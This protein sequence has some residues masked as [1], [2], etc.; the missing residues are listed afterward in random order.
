MLETHIVPINLNRLSLSEFSQLMTT[1]LRALEQKGVKLE[2]FPHIEGAIKRLEA[3]LPKLDVG[4][5]QEKPVTGTD[6]RQA[7]RVRAQDL[8]HIF[9]MVSIALASRKAEKREAAQELDKLLQHYRQVSRDNYEKESKHI[10]QLLN[11][12]ASQSY[13]EKISQVGI[14]EQ[15]NNLKAS[16]E[17][18]YQ[19]YLTHTHYRGQ[20]IGRRVQYDRKDI[21]NQYKILYQY[22]LCHIYWDE[23]SPLK[24]ILMS[25]ND[26]RINYNQLI[27]RREKRNKIPDSDV[28]GEVN[29]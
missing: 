13:R 20:K 4:I 28:L 25:L 3:S 7:D 21:Q 24:P 18:F 16:Q 10:N 23:N 6:L 11:R 1:S 22:L 15:V 9:M 27:S 5:K 12:L 2:D 14:E 29:P 19:L 8:K 17:I 26:C